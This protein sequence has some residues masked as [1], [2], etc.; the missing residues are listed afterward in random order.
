MLLNKKKSAFWVKLTAS[1]VALAFILSVV[2]MITPSSVWK[3][4]FERPLTS[5][6]KILYDQ[7]RVL[8]NK[9]KLDSR[10]TTSLVALGVAYYDWGY[11]LMGKK[12]FSEGES[13]MSRA[14]AAYEKS[15]EIDSKNASVW[16]TLGNV[17]FDWGVY[18]LFEA[19][20]K[21]RAEDKMSR[22]IIAY[23]KSLEID[24]KNF[25]VRTDMG[26]AY[27]YLGNTKKAIEEFQTVIR[28]VPT[29]PNAYYNLGLTLADEGRK[30]EAIEAFKKCL[31]LIPEGQGADEVRR[32]IAELE[33]S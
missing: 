19:K 4:A 17:Y 33:G 5:E 2:V 30:K 32:K 27:R 7:I 18:L 14:V 10:D 13:K 3:S 31:G 28:N 12:K 15:L 25:D 11:Y 29:H 16:A 8:E 9:I 23:Q 20:D 24:P 6:E 21:K 22:A 1:V 26:S